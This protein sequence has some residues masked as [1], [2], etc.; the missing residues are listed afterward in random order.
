MT[1]DD[2]AIGNFGMK[3]DDLDDEEKEKVRS[4]ANKLKGMS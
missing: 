2:I 3:Y 1:L 4:M